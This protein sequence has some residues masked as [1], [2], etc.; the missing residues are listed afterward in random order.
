MMMEIQRKLWTSRYEKR[1]VNCGFCALMRINSMGRS[2]SFCQGGP[3][4]KPEN[5]LDNVFY[6]IFV[7]RHQIIL[8]F[9]LKSTSIQQLTF[10]G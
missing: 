5:S 3:G 2:R 4:R 6:F 8:H 9:R 7:V 1:G 10:R